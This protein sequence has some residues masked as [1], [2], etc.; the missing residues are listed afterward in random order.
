MSVIDVPNF[1]HF[2]IKGHVPAKAT[3]WISN[4]RVLTERA[5][6]N[7]EGARTM[8]NNE[9][10]SNNLKENSKSKSL[11]NRSDTILCSAMCC[12]VLSI[13][14]G[15]HNIKQKKRKNKLI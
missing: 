4:R 3:S 7:K 12:N 13:Y 5:A 9:G 6:R 2:R 15:G 14:E 1:M 8:I 11:F 10:C